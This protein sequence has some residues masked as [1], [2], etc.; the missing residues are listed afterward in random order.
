MLKSSNAARKIVKK[1]WDAVYI[2]AKRF[3]IVGNV[4]NVRRWLTKNVI[5]VKKNAA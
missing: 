1:F 4:G 2:N 3:V 5:V